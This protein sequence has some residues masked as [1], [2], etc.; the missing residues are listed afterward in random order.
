MRAA[1]TEWIGLRSAF[2]QSLIDLAADSISSTTDPMLIGLNDTNATLNTTPINTEEVSYKGYEYRPETYIVPIIFGIIFL[3]GLMGNG[4]LIAVF[5]KHRA[6]RNVPNTWVTFLQ[7]NEMLSTSLRSSRTYMQITC[8]IT[9][10]PNHSLVQCCLVV[11]LFSISGWISSLEY[12]C[13]YRSR[14]FSSKS[15]NKIPS[16]YY[17]WC[18]SQTTKMDLFRRKM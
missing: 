14:F 12:I 18:W 10:I 4:M 13:H 5:I 7:R 9:T 1:T 6:M 16:N 15:G 11:V 3:A 17:G 2:T 8:E